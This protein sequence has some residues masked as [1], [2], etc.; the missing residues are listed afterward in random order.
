M[1]RLQLSVTGVKWAVSRVHAWQHEPFE[2]GWS[3][4]QNL[5]HLLAVEKANYHVRIA[6][7][8]EE[9]TPELVA[10]DNDAAMA[11]EGSEGSDIEALAERFMAARTTTFEMF[12][13]L[14]PEQWRRTAVWPDGT[15]VDLS[16]IAEKVLWHALVHFAT[17]LDIHQEFEPIQAK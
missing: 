7:V 5:V 6:R 1:T 4:H 13:D 10:W 8:L 14:S 11:A 15:V 3:A 2:G 12:K 16:W 17:L 9:N